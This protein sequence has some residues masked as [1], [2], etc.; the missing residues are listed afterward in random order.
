[1]SFAFA[2]HDG[3]AFADYAF[4]VDAFTYYAFHDNAF[5]DLMV[6][7]MIPGPG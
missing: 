1:M 6:T 5:A 7:L 4:A 3:V 2:G